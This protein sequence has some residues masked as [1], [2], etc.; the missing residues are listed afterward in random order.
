MNNS[1]PTQKKDLTEA[2][3]CNNLKEIKSQS[4]NKR[5]GTPESKK[6]SE[7]QNQTQIE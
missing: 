5:T 3:M 6:E 2:E 4:I 1:S 7:K